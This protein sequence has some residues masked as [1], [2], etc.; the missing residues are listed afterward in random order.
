MM[1]TTIAMAAGITMGG[2]NHAFTIQT[3][4]A[5]SMWLA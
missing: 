4:G 2:T 1:T 3:P 5:C